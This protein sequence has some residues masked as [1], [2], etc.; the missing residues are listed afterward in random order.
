[1]TDEGDLLW[2]PSAERCADARVT[3][4]RRWLA[5]ERGIDLADEAALW[6]W[7]VEEL[8]TFWASI[9]DYC[10]VRASKPYDDVLAV[11]TMPG[12][13]WF[14]GAELSY[15]EHALRWTGPDPALIYRREDGRQT[16]VTRDELRS[17]V[18]TCAAG[19]RR[20]G[21]GPGDRVAAVLPN[22][23]ETVVAFLTTASIGAIWSSCSPDFGTRGLIDRIAQIEPTVLLGVD[24][25]LYGGKV[26]STVENLAQLSAALQ[27]RLRATVVLPYVDV[28]PDLGAV[29]NASTWAEL[30]GIAADLHCTRMPFDAPLWILYSSGTTGL[31]KAIVHSQGGILLEHLKN[32]TLHTDL[33][34]GDRFFW[35]TTTGWMMWNFLLSGLLVGATCVL[36]DG[37]PAHPDLGALW[38]LAG[39]DNDG[40]GITTFG[41]SAPYL[42]S[43]QNAGIV[44]K[45]IADLSALASIG[46]TG[47]PLPPE[48]FQWCYDNVK[49]D[50][51]LA[52]VS[53][54]TD[55]CSGFVLGFPT[56]PVHAG[57]I[58]S[59]GLGIA[60]ETYD[61]LGRPVI[62]EVGELVITKPMP[63]M[64]TKFWN[65][66]DGSKYVDSYFA[67]FPGVWRHGDWAKI[68]SRGTVV[69][70]GRS[71]STLNRG[72]VRIGTSEF[73]RVV[74]EMPEVTDS[75][76]IDTSA[77]GVEGR[78]LLFVVLADG[79]VLDDNLLTHIRSILRAQLSPRHVP[80]VIE[81]IP[82]VPRTLN[83][84][85]LEVPV[86]KLLAGVELDTAVS[87]GAVSN[88]AA[89]EPFVSFAA[90]RTGA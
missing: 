24:G 22:C 89:L 30:M 62:G 12:A 26:H 51:H 42:L 2:T 18:A 53:G 59:R 65:D 48:G 9:W 58:Q 5:H 87:L 36:Y 81:A 76:V 83:G 80:D 43:C 45:D 50:L 20:L 66:P 71:D 49:A 10:D 13:Q 17:L 8:E 70:Y 34:P 79:V 7:S 19:L 37:S 16:T 32:A 75:L 57:E 35:F 29:P 40:V 23:P 3:R 14:P 63:S 77:L 4:Y 67:T 73:Y 11:D 68:T 60:A 74:D 56:L 82:E 84:K 72:G 46:S 90:R 39:R 31:P 15:A 86:K 88:P 6:R 54:G 1:V 55:V 38:R 41:T 33:E 25:Y 64:P 44:P 69:I 85:K 61:E 27:P 52:S 28:N 78:L 21:V 47:A